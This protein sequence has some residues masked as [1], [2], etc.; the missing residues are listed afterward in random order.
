MVYYH[1]FKVTI[2][3]NTFKV[4]YFST[5]LKVKK[6]SILLKLSSGKCPYSMTDGPHGSILLLF[7]HQ[8]CYLN[9]KTFPR[10][11][12]ST[13]LL[14]FFETGIAHCLLKGC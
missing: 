9:F 4:A 8:F 1:I 11:I 14:F 6:I 3:I 5:S 12:S 2:K 7:T 13:D 10:R